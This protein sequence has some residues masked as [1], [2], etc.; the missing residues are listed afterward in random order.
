MTRTRLWAV[1]AALVLALT[2]TAAGCG[3][4]DDDGGGGG[5]ANVS[6]KTL[7]VGSDIPFP[8]FEQG[9]APD[10]TG[11]DID[12]VNEIAKR[13]GFKVEYEDTPF[14]TIFTDLANDKFDFVVSAATIT[15]EREQTVDFSDPYYRANQALTVTSDSD[16][17]TVDDLEG[18]TVGAQDGTTGEAYANDETP[19]A[20]VRGYPEGP[21]A[22]NALRSGQVDAVIIDQP[23]AEDAIEKGQDV[24]ITQIPTGE[25]YGIVFNEADDSL[26]E[27]V[28]GALKEMKD[29]GTLAKFYEKWFKLKP[30]KQVLEGTNEPK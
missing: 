4:D 6:G 26:R 21:D 11:Y 30:P 22:I 9:R 24:K 17:T 25:L 19:A 1:L 14:D 5:G 15:P 8:P 12:V 18:Q 13:L 28:N 10:Y 16:I 2:A 20:D 27:D 3:D 29:D 7:T 23:V